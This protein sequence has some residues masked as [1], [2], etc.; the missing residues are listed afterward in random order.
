MARGRKKKAETKGKYT[1]KLAALSD[2]EQSD[3][4]VRHSMD[5]DPMSPASHESHESHDATNG[6]GPAKTDD[7]VEDEDEKDEDEDEDEDED[8]YVD[9]N[10]PRA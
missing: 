2:D 10:W 1:K 7:A 6:D 4:E 9:T 3:F 8:V 5:V